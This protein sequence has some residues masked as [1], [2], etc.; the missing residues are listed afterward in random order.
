MADDIFEWDDLKARR[1][2]RKH[3]VSFPQ[4]VEAFSDAF[5]WVEEDVSE[6][7]GEDRFILI[8]RALDGILCVV[9]TERAERIHIISAREATDHERKIYYRAAQE[10]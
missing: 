1:N 7:Y 10:E 2:L 6:D 9:Y 4:A 3:G 8:G 5:A